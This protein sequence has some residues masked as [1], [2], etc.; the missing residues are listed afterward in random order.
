M[1]T[2]W[3]RCPVA[4]AKALIEAGRVKVGWTM[5]RVQSLDPRPMRCYRCLLTGHV[6]RRCTAGEDCSDKCYHCGQGSHKAA[7]CAEPSPKCWYCA[8]ANRNSDHRVGSTKQCRQRPEP[9]PR[10]RLPTGGGD[11]MDT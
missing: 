1:G 3:V 11:S 7:R 5:A 2:V 10:R 4:A 8:A 6:G 9:Q